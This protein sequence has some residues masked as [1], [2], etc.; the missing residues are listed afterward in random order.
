MDSIHHMFFELADI[1][2]I[3]HG[4]EVTLQDRITE[5]NRDPRSDTIL[6]TDTFKISHGHHTCRLPE[7]GQHSVSV[8]SIVCESWY[9]SIRAT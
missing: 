1:H 7:F 6:S 4:Q 2:S 9:E 3:V 8:I 5:V